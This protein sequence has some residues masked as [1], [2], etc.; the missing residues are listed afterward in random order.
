[1]EYYHYSIRQIFFEIPSCGKHVNFVTE[2]V[3]L[4]KNLHFYEDSS[5]TLDTIEDYRTQIRQNRKE[6]Y[7]QEVYI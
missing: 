2:F 5:W 6:N 3:I 7:L 4:G 1:M